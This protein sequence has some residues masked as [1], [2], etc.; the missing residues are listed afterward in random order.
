MNITF[1]KSQRSTLQ[2][3]LGFIC[4]PIRPISVII[5]NYF[6]Q[7]RFPLNLMSITI[8]QSEKM[9]SFILVELFGYSPKPMHCECIVLILYYSP[10]GG[11]YQLFIDSSKMVLACYLNV[12]NSPFNCR[13]HSLVSVLFLHLSKHPN[14]RS[15]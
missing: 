11:E 12:T 9:S 1:P 14:T 13:S 15:L 10:I 8:P 4:S 2:I 6:G 7:Y 3:K 5:F